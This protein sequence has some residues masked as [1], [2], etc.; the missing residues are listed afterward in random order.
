MDFL[1]SRLIQKRS[2]VNLR[3]IYYEMKN[4]IQSLSG[5]IPPEYRR[6]SEA[7]GWCAKAVD[8]LADRIIPDGFRNDNFQ[9]EDIYRLNNADI[10]YDSAVLSALVSSCSFIYIGADA[11]GFP[12]LQVIDGGNATGIIDPVTNMLT[13]GYAVL[14]RNENGMPVSEAY[15]TAY[16][17]FYR[18]IRDGRIYKENFSHKAPFALLVPIIYRPDARRPFGHSRISRSCISI[19]NNVLRTLQRAEITG[20]FY[21]FPQKYVLGTSDELELE[22]RL[23]TVSSFLRINKDEDGDKPTFGQFQSASLA[24]YSEY[25]KTMAS[26]FAGETGLTLDD[27]GFVT[28]NPSS[29]EA[30]RSAHENLRLTA[31]KAQRTFSTGFINAGYLS[32]CVRDNFEYRRQ[33]IADTQMTF[34]PIFEPD[35]TAIASI[36]DAVYKINQVIPNYIGK[37]G[38]KSL[39]GIK[40]G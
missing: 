39:T 32:A 35:S 20:E 15:F 9:I 28:S 11:D 40:E 19:V 1:K 5:I 36:G 12:R 26:L 17:T 21:S 29:A 2:R 24:P 37:D 7:L 16:N 18:Y 6:F 4:E 23:A 33:A 25:L 30:I 3:Y 34:A 22:G 14:E 8:T 10:L 13:E 27:L 31:R 38:I